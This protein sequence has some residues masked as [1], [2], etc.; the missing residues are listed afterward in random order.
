MKFEADIYGVD[1]KEVE[2]ARRRLTESK[3][4]VKSDLENNLAKI[5]EWEY[6]YCPD[7]KTIRFSADLKATSD[8]IC[9]SKCQSQRLEAPGWVECPHHKDSYVKCPRA[10]KGIVKMKYGYECHDHCYFRTT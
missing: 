2:E 10:G 5:E 6:C 3:Q 8:G 1:P 9:C 4:E 7:C